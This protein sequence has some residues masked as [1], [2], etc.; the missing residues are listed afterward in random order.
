MKTQTPFKTLLLL[1]LLVAAGGFSQQAM[2]QEDSC[3]VNVVR[4]YINGRQIPWDS[5]QVRVDFNN[6]RFFTMYGA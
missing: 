2:A 5:I 3:I 6:P 4:T 1:A